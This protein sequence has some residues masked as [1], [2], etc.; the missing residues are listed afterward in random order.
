MSVSVIFLRRGLCGRSCGTASSLTVVGQPAVGNRLTS[1]KPRRTSLR[2]H[3]LLRIFTQAF[4]L[5]KPGIFP[6]LIS[7]F[8]VETVCFNVRITPVYWGN[9]DVSEMQ[10]YAAGSSMVK[11]TAATFAV[12][13]VRERF[14]RPV[15]WG[16]RSGRRVPDDRLAR[17]LYSGECESIVE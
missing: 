8:E 7:P 5:Q 10:Y 11:S 2:E 1:T 3:I 14:F 6:L 16:D 15:F 9:E 17:S 4:I 13:D 12:M